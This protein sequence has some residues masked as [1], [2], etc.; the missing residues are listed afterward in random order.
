LKVNIVSQNHKMVIAKIAGIVTLL[1]VALLSVNALAQDD[2]GAPDKLLVA[3]VDAPPFYMKTPDG[4]WEGL[5]IEL[6][7]A[8]AQELGVEFDL[9]EFDT[10]GQELDAITRG[11]VD[12]IL[13]LPVAERYEVS[14]DLS[15]PFLRSGAAIAVA[16]EGSEH[17]WLRFAGRLFSL[18]FLPVI[19]LL[20]LLALVAGTIVWLFESRR[21]PKMFG[22]GTVRGIG[23]GIWWAIVTLTT[24]GYGDKAPK[25]LGGRMVALIW[26]FASIILI[27][28]FTAAITTSFTVGELRGKIRGLSDLPDVR[29]GS[30][31]QSES[32]DFLAKRGIAVRPFKNLRDGLQAIV[33]KKIDAFFL[34]ELILKH[35]AKTEFSGRVHVLP[36]TFDHYYLSMAL[37][38]GSPLREQLNRAL[39]KIITRDD[40]FRLVKSYIGPDR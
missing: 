19:G 20:L 31:A 35:L 13:A 38:S 16:A 8:V 39:L 23:Q 24:V 5:S 28:S 12:V 32:L 2:S 34:N 14:M 4:R 22:G 21:N 10:L 11:E 25:T 27:A 15:H 18:N 40:W 29:V 36:G 9:R 33:D 6:W 30:L 26:M 1:I 37:P 17:S 3:V 7:Q